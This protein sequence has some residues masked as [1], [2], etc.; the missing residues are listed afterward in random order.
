M[1]LGPARFTNVAALLA[2]R[3][4]TPDARGRSTTSPRV[5]NA[6]PSCRYEDAIARALED[7]ENALVALDDQAAPAGT[8]DAGAASAERRLATRNRSTTAGRP[9]SCRCST[10]SAS[11]W[12]WV[13]ANEAD[14]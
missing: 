13:S 2:M 6:K 3:S 4:S 10:L 9:I 7:V 1:A 8:T 12:S 14:T 5:D 11:G